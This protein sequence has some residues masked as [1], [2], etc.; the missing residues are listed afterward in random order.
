MNNVTLVTI[1]GAIS[2]LNNRI[3]F[4]CGNHGCLIKAPKGMGT[5]MNCKCTPE[6]IRKD[7]LGIA[8]AIESM[9]KEWKKP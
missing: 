2:H 4:G 9:G 5:N 1:Q 8:L 3:H 6:K 7:I